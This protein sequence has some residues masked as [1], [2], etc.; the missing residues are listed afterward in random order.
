MR[1]FFDKE[2]QFES[3]LVIEDLWTKFGEN[4]RKDKS[5]ISKQIDQAKKKRIED[6]I[7]EF[8]NEMKKNVFSVYILYVVMA[9]VNIL[10]LDGPVNCLGSQGFLIDLCQLASVC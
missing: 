9:P 5:K 1:K 4:F 6:L 10:F 3:D 7:K 8:I 2:I